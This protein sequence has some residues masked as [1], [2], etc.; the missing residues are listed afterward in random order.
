MRSVLESWTLLLAYLFI[1]S[2]WQAL[3]VSAQDSTTTGATK[4][5]LQEFTEV[6]YALAGYSLEMQDTI[7]NWAIV[8]EVVVTL[9][10]VWLAWYCWKKLRKTQLKLKA[11]QPSIT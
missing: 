7:L 3:Q 9:P 2:A 5:E 1:G 10:F 4:E 6:A 8:F 11:P